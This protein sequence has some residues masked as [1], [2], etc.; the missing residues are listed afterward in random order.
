MLAGILADHA[1][2]CCRADDQQASKIAVAMLADP[3]KAFL[4]T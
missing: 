1:H 2:D 3:S 4:A